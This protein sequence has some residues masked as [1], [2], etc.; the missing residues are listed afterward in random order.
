MSV[1]TPS[2][3]ADGAHAD[4][5]QV[6]LE[7]CAEV[8]ADD[9]ERLALFQ[10]ALVASNLRADHEDDDRIGVLGQNPFWGPAAARRD[11]RTAANVFL[12]EARRIKESG[13]PRSAHRLAVQVQGGGSVWKHKLASKAA[14]RILDEAQS[15]NAIAG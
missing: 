10:A 11:P 12:R 5:I 15:S 8:K 6:L 14:Q 3:A 1:Q 2:A 9:V 4:V 7:A 13:G